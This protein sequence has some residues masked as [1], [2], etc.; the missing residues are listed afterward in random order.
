LTVTAYGRPAELY[1][2]WV[3]TRSDG[4]VAAIRPG[5]WRDRAGGLMP[6]AE[7]ACVAWMLPEERY[8]RTANILLARVE[9]CK[10]EFL[11]RGLSS[12]SEGYPISREAIDLLQ[13]WTNGRVHR[14]I[15][16]SWRVDACGRVVSF[17]DRHSINDLGKHQSEFVAAMQRLGYVC[18]ARNGRILMIPTNAR[19]P[20]KE[21]AKQVV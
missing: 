2:E 14:D 15:L 10:G 17:V 4:A 21:R 20:M 11:M 1:Q 7:L 13:K 5:F 8:T 16:G 9:E 3:A 19:K 12:P 6:H 18:H